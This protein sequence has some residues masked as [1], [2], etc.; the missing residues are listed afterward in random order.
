MKHVWW[1][2]DICTSEVPC[3]KVFQNVGS[4]KPDSQQE[5]AVLG[6]ERLKMEGVV[7]TSGYIRNVSQFL[8]GNILILFRVLVNLNLQMC[9]VVSFNTH[10]FLYNLWP[11]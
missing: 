8:S 10:P 9:Y 7:W 11:L 6:R 3:A 2:G 1:T 5:V 4:L